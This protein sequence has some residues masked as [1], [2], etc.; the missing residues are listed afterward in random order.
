MKLKSSRNIFDSL[1]FHYRINKICGYLFFSIRK[2]ESEKFRVETT[3]YDV[4]VFITSF[5]IT[6]Y[7]LALILVVPFNTTSRSI[8]IEISTFLYLKT[9]VLHPVFSIIN[10]FYH[11]YG[12]FNIIQNLQ[13]I[14]I[15][16]RIELY[17]LAY[18]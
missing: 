17:L 11:R 16:V 18:L 6:C 14:D 9:V 15:K 5:C 2:D 13:W 4:I 1:E 7:A 12:M 8:I 3:F 10:N